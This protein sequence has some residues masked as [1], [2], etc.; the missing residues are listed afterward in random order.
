MVKGPPR[1]PSGGSG[2]HAIQCPFHA[3]V[4]LVCNRDLFNGHGV[5]ELGHQRLTKSF[6]FDGGQFEGGGHCFEVRCGVIPLTP[7]IYTHGIPPV[8]HQQLARRSQCRQWVLGGA[9][10]YLDTAA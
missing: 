1:G 10:E 5:G 8:N 6:N 3:G 4:Q 2:A 9:V 7:S